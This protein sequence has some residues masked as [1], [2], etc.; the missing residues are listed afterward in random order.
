METQA[1][2]SASQHHDMQVR[3]DEKQLMPFVD[4]IGNVLC[5]NGEWLSNRVN[6]SA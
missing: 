5:F 4:D 6:A 2:D 3:G 1:T